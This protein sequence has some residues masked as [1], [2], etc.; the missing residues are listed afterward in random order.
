MSKTYTV[1]W[2]STTYYTQEVQADSEDD[3]RNKVF[4][5]SVDIPVV[6]DYTS[7]VRMLQSIEEKL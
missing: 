3:A 7:G 1:R 2:T 4:D 6:L 5:K